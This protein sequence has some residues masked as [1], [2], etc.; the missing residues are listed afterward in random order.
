MTEPRYQVL[1][2]DQPLSQGDL[3]LDCPVL[4][5]K[6]HDPTTPATPVPLAERATLLCEDVIVMTQACD[7]EHHQ[8]HDV[9]LCRHIPLSAYRQKDWAPWMTARG[10]AP[11]EKVWR[12]F[13]EDIAA[14]Y[15][16]NLSF[17]DRFEHPTLATEVW[18]V[19]FH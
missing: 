2:A 14:G 8:V 16:W 15:V 6:R 3:I 9:V 7:L 4:V 11:S 10:Q 18:I 13:C 5:W 19:N 1:D 12:R 17:L